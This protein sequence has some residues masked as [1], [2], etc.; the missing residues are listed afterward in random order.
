MEYGK[1]AA[2]RTARQRPS[3]TKR[4]RGAIVIGWSEGVWERREFFLFW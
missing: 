1:G 2:V 3:A 4:W